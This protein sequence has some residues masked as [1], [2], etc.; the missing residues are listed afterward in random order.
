M[1][2]II[3]YLF[4]FI[5]VVL[6]QAFVFDN[7]VLPRGFV[8]S[9]YVIYLLILP[10]NTKPI[11]LML[12]AFALGLSIDALNDTYGLNASAAIT[13]A[14]VRPTIFKWFEPAAGY[15]E[16]Q[17]PNLA[18]M[19]WNWTIK[20]YLLN[21]LAF[22]TWYYVLGFL[23]LS[24]FWFTASKILYSSLAT[25]LVILMAQTLFRRKAK[26]NEI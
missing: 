17:N 5:G 24:G 12:I 18:Q 9:F 21:I 1:K 10:I 16:S 13:L 15:N 19:G 14:V 2:E 22:Y 6:L 11:L 8:I 7:I 25:L 23:R 20:V 3:T 4:W 26:Q